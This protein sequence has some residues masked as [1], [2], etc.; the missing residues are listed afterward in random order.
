MVGTVNSKMHLIE[1]YSG[2]YDITRG[3]NHPIMVRYSKHSLPLW[4]HPLRPTQEVQSKIL[5]LKERVVMHSASL[6]QTMAFLN[7]LSLAP[8]NWKKTEEVENGKYRQKKIR[9]TMD[10][11]HRNEYNACN[12]VTICQ[13]DI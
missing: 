10:V 13:N 4:N 2:L 6:D 11:F 7:F 8:D 3:N 9:G 12:K 5:A 1:T